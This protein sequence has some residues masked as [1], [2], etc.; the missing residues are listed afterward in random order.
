MKMN[1]QS[2]ISD[3][4]ATLSNNISV[5]Y[6]RNEIAS[7]IANLYESLDDD[8]FNIDDV[9]TELAIMYKH[10]LPKAGKVAKNIPEYLQKFK[11]VKDVR[12]YL[13]FVY[14]DGDYL[15]AING[16]YL[17]YTPN[18]DKLEPGFYDQLF[19]KVEMDAKYPNWQRAVGD[20]YSDKEQITLSDLEVIMVKEILC[21]K[22][23]DNL[24]VNKQYLDI[25]ANGNDVLI[26][27]KTDNIA[28]LSGIFDNTATV[29][30]GVRH[31]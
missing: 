15:V 18:V 21:Y 17:T 28:R 25:T 6:K 30:M 14:C 31:D 10:F 9:K 13:N 4:I 24:I 16:H 26:V 29:L 12:Y 1:K 11:D 2:N 22:L 5:K 8:N 7:K 20:D 27:E 19:N 23:D 3:N